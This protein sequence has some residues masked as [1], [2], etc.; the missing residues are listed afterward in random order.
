[1]LNVSGSSHQ[2]EREIEESES[3]EREKVMPEGPYNEP[4]PATTSVI[5]NDV[6]EPLD[7]GTQGQPFNPNVLIFNTSSEN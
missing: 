2:P 3:I 7:T 4:P 1:M 5:D 6:F